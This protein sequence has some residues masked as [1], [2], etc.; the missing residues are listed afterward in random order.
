MDMNRLCPHCMRE[1]KEEMSGSCPYCGYQSSHAADIQHQLKPFTILSG[2]YL[3]GDVLGEGGFGITYIGFDINLEV[4]IAIKEFYPNGFA[5]RESNVTSELTA[6]QGQSME[7][8][9]K[10]RDN[11]LDEARRLAKCSHLSGV[12][13]VRDFF[14]ENN[15][16]YI[17]QEYI[18]GMTLKD[19]AQSAGGKM[20]A[21]QL[22]A[23][24]KPVLDALAQVHREG[25]VHRDISPDNIMR[26]DNGQ[27]KLLDF[28]AARDFAASGEKSLSVLLKPGYAPEEQYRTK[29]K[30]GPWSDIYAFAG[31]I[32]K[33]ITGVTP[34]ESMERMRQDEL[35]RPG[36]LGAEIAPDAERALLKAL[37][38]YAE[39]RYQSIEDLC[40]DLYGSGQAAVSSTG[41]ASG[42][43]SADRASDAD[44]R[45]S[46]PEG[47]VPQDGA[48]KGKRMIAAASAAGAVVCLLLFVLFKQAGGK[49]TSKRSM[50]TGSQQAAA[51]GSVGTKTDA[52]KDPADGLEQNSGESPEDMDA[53]KDMKEAEDDEA[54]DTEASEDTDAAEE[55]TE[56]DRAL[57]A[58]QEYMDDYFA[59]YDESVM[60]IS[61]GVESPV[62]TLLYLD[63][64]D[65]IPVCFLPLVHN[66]Q[67]A[68]VYRNG[69]IESIPQEDNNIGIFS[70][71]KENNRI[72][73]HP[74]VMMAYSSDYFFERDDNGRYKEIGCAAVDDGA[75]YSISKGA[76]SKM[77]VVDEQTYY[78]Y[79]V[80]FGN[81]SYIEGAAAGNVKEA[82]QLLAETETQETD[83]R[84]MF[85]IYGDGDKSY[86]GYGTAE[87]QLVVDSFGYYD[88]RIGDFAFS[89]PLRTFS[90]VEYDDRSYK[91]AYG[92]NIQSIKFT[93]DGGGSLLFRLSRRK[94]SS[95]MAKMADAVYQQEAGD[96]SGAAKLV[97]SVK[98]DHAR[99]VMTGY[100]A[101]GG[102][103][104]E[105]IKTDSKY[106]MQMK[107]ICPPYEDEEDQL[108]KGYLTECIYRLCKFSGSGK[109]V[110]SYDEYAQ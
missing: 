20:P 42:A 67:E 26:M 16:A 60:D 54:A 94:D 99:V 64:D 103:V 7:T 52:A 43:V 83:A 92:K 45:G 14:Q 78:E 104:Y 106:V 90:E 21:G 40:R 107:F 89:Y 38:V 15:T 23:E 18:E 81:F 34:P 2:K 8:V 57:E 55:A 93:E 19:Y 47:I 61:F 51:E 96:M 70:F 41:P 105:V 71:Q 17:V 31:T 86:G 76:S 100:D 73:L 102:I 82:Y 68:I 84:R 95:S 44:P 24:I 85:G 28:G 37:S 69:R 59:D 1:I 91:N 22:L 72:K 66:R 48:K 97:S 74:T 3:V 12:V 101:G 5:T 35:R 98:P 75:E 58:Y 10:W 46:A 63:E 11:F 33:C 49:D 87:E 88:S 25:I 77:Q 30:Q 79:V 36:E 109:W 9:Y 32:Y 108:E 4:R 6:Y 65:E 62:C 29:G 80:S 110:R 27:M 56:L 39:D 50:D 13:G 53:G